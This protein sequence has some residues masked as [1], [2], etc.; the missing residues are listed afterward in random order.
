MGNILSAVVEIEGFRPYFWHAFGPEA[1]PLEK[2]ERTGVAG[3][4]PESW[5][6]TVLFTPDKKRQ[7]FIWPTYVF[8]CLRD[9]AKHTKSGKGSIQTKVESTLQVTDS[10]IYFD[11]CLPLEKDLRTNAFTDPV[12]I[13]Q[14]GTKN[15]STKAKNVCYR[16]VASPPWKLTFHIEW[17]K[18]VVSR[19]QMQAVA[20]DS[21]Q[22]EGLGNARKIGMG[23]FHVREFQVKELAKAA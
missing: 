9:G 12:Y 5:K 4:D 20:I 23:R 16:I 3:N 8:R 10:V 7:L 21:G 22:L 2:G 11:R 13:D 14:R 19:E 1:I 15:P 6:K 17:D 18:T